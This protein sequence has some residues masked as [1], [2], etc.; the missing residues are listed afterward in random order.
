[1]QADTSLNQL[2]LY[3]RTGFE[4]ECAAEISHQAGRAGVSGYVKAKPGDGYVVYACH[5]QDG[6]LHGLERLAF[7][8]LVF[9]RQW[10]AAAPMVEGL[11]TSDRVS[12]L[13]DHIRLLGACADLSVEHI[14]SNEGKELSRLCRKITHPLRAAMKAS[15]LLKQSSRRLLHVLFLDG[16]RAFVGVSEQG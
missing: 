8:E 12:V 3:C 7:D 1:M 14:D 10:F 15:K 9:A 6:A 13:L 16:T 4:K 5:Q 2:V 11:P